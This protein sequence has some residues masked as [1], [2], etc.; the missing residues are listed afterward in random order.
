M[1]R[2][3]A[4]DRTAAPTAATSSSCAAAN[5][6]LDVIEDEGLVANARER[7]GQLL[8]G[9]RRAARPATRRSATCAAS[10]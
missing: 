7:G 6:T 2:L 3:P 8:A 4:R 10:G 1:D 9:L 5:A